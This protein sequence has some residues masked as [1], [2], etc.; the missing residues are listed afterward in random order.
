MITTLSGQ[1]SFMLQRELRRLIDGFVAEH[2]D[3]GLERLDGDEAGYDRIRESLESLPFLAAR[4]LVVL[5]QPGADKQFAE[6]AER[7]LAALPETTDVIL[8]EPKLD[9]RLSYYKYL[10]KSTEFKEFNE[11]DGSQLAGWLADEAK[12]RGGKLA[13]ADAAF[14]V[15]RVGANQQ[16]LD[17]ELAKLLL[18]DPQVT[19]ESILLLTEQ[20]PMSTIFDLLDAALN[21]RTA[22]ALELYEEQRAA[23]VEPIQIIALL[24]WQLHI[25][26]LIKTAAGRDAG[27][28]ASEA[29]LNPYV[30]RKSMSIAGRLTLAEVKIL[31]RSV[32][33]L[34]IRL[35]SVSIDPDEAMR[36]L[37]VTLGQ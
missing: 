22:R 13:R 26:A 11:L 17:N 27:S 23:K 8:V 1:N 21:G 16:M 25:L 37:I 29:K 31:I 34:D 4:K 33:D 15:S 28:I 10:K 30:V 18:Y 6:N 3:M 32:R 35:K 2:T 20:A 14:L 5:R 36:G 7:L 12:H 9:K 19:R 24:A